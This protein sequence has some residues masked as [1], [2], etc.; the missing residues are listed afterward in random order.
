MICEYYTQSM[1]TIFP[2]NPTIKFNVNNN[3]SNANKNNIIYSIF[4]IQRIHS[5]LL[6]YITDFNLKLLSQLKLY[7]T[8]LSKVVTLLNQSNIYYNDY[9][10]SYY[11]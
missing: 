5:T 3:L 9:I 6:Y 2:K 1:N 8:N 10:I 7:G 4:I 11:L